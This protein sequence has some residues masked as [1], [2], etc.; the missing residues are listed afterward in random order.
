LTPKRSIDLS[1]QTFPKLLLL[2]VQ[3]TDYKTY[4]GNTLVMKECWEKWTG[5][6]IF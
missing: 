4:D 6:T 3:N 5:V 1:L 2:L